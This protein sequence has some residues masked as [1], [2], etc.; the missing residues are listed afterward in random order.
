MSRTTTNTTHRPETFGVWTITHAGAVR[1]ATGER[2]AQFLAAR[3]ANCDH[4]TDDDM[5]LMA[6][7]VADYERAREHAAL[8][9]RALVPLAELRAPEFEA[10]EDDARAEAAE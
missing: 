8:K 9:P 4:T 2:P 3:L 10:F 1:L 5:V 7:F 6:S